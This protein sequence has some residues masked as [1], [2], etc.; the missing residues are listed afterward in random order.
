MGEFRRVSAS[1]C[2]LERVRARVWASLGQF[3][4]VWA[5]SSEFGRDRAS[6]IEFE[7]DRAS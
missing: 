4:R 1:L 3:E 2:E 7:R 6:L 5:S